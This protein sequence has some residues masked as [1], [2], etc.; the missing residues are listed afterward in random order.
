MQD[1][2]ALK[3]SLKKTNVIRNASTVKARNSATRVGSY[4]L[5]AAFKTEGR[6]FIGTYPG[7]NWF[8]NN[9]RVPW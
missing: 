9:E 4:P 7:N 5:E 6:I 3:P 1:T 2:I 8:V